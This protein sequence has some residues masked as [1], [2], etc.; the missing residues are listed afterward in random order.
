MA[1]A[2]ALDAC[3]TAAL[4]GRRRHPHRP[5]AGTLVVA[6]PDADHDLLAQL[7]AGEM[8]LTHYRP[9]GGLGLLRQGDGC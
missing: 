5:A 2:L 6:T 8:A 9:E 4:S 3:A 7:L 1:L